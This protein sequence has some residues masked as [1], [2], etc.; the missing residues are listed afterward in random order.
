MLN[1]VVPSAVLV[2]LFDEER[3]EGLEVLL[4]DLV[5]VDFLTRLLE[6]L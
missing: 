1:A 5:D 2:T 4:T 3:V 6:Q